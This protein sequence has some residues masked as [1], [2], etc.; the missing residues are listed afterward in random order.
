MR[1]YEDFTTQNRASQTWTPDS[2]NSL[3][4]GGR[5]APYFDTRQPSYKL[6]F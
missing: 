6:L 2:G 4:F 1:F 5:L 3:I